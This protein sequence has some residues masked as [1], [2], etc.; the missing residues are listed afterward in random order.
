MSTCVHGLYSKQQ[1]CS[2]IVGFLLDV[3]KHESLDNDHEADETSPSPICT[4][5]KS[6]AKKCL[7]GEF[8]GLDF[9]VFTRI[10]KVNHH[11]VSPVGCHRH[12]LCSTKSTW[13]DDISNPF[14]SNHLDA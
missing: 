7:G 6:P 2:D 5:A 13:C 4:A 12:G 1:P 11:L 10:I 8:Y 9:S 3:M 14:S